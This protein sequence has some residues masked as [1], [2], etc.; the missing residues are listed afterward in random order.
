MLIDWLSPG[1]SLLGVSARA[2]IRR[3][4]RPSGAGGRGSL[5][6]ALRRHRTEAALQH[7]H[8]PRLARHAA[9]IPRRQVSQLTLSRIDYLLTFSRHWFSMEDKSYCRMCAYRS[10]N[11][12]RLLSIQ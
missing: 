8:V 6:A 7:V 9:H 5:A 3:G 4:L 11:N 10:Y 12:F 2:A 1:D